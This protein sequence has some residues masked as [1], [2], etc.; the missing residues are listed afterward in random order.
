[1]KERPILFN[2][3]MVRAV[4]EGRKAQTR[5]PLKPQP[6]ANGNG[7]I[8]SPNKKH[9]VFGVS[10]SELF[11]GAVSEYCPLGQPGD[12]LW[13]RETFWCKNDS[14]ERD[15]AESLDCGSMLSLGPD[16]AEINYFASPECLDPPKAHFQ[17]TI[18]EWQGEPIP[19]DWWLA[20]PL[21]WDG[22]CDQQYE[23]S[24]E[25]CFVPWQYYTKHPSIHMPRWASRIDL[26]ITNV[27]VERVQDISEEDARAE[28]ISLTDKI[29][30]HDD[31]RYSL[32]SSTIEYPR[33]IKKFASIWDSIY[34]NWDENPWVWVIEFKKLT[35]S[36]GKYGENQ[37][38]G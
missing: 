16:Y 9:S 24:G 25:W 20:P 37:H 7:L 6:V 32:G 27:R 17:Q 10:G 12:R 1:M 14:E 4:L 35:T 3:E 30:I 28:G 36:G 34:K 38:R 13:V 29:S 19:G 21:F 31:E 15:Y 33:T 11:K 26:E 5:R 22:S 8:W 2:S 23:E 18:S